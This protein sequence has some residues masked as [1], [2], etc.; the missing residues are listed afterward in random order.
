[1]HQVMLGDRRRLSAYDRALQRTVRPGDVVADV[2]AGLLPLSLLAIGHGARHVY[3]LEADPETV[4]VARDIVSRNG[5]EDRV[6]VMEGDA[7]LARLPEKAD[8][9]VSEMMGNLGPEEEMAAIIAAVARNN[10]RPGARL[11]PERL[12]TRVQA[13]ELEEGWG[14]WQQ[15]VA[16]YSLN[17][18]V[19]YAVGGTQLH[20]FN[21]R[22][23]LLTDAA[24][25]GDSR[26]GEADRSRSGTLG[27]T[28]RKVGTLHAVMG[29]FTATLAPGIELSN[30]PSY[31]GCNWAVCVW[32][33]Q[34][35]DVV[36]G[37]EIRVE[38]HRPH[39]VRVATDW[40]LN[41]GLARK[42]EP[43]LPSQ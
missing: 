33:M 40:R 14:V 10:L 28:V 31:R 4:R 9:L 27:L 30:F 26:M 41:C 43:Y 20:F 21:G 22:P 11:V 34:P 25:I 23:R 19:E 17:A 15:P 35:T 37:D 13:V 39:D 18:V 36:P 38:V 16:G 8:V 32:P 7:R 1:M 2:G 29:Y 24:A 6:T 42:A 5:L 3:A 12:V